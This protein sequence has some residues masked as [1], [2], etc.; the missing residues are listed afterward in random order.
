MQLVTETNTEKQKILLVDK[1][2]SRLLLLLKNELRK[3][4]N[5]VF[6]SPKILPTLNSFDLCFVLHEPFSSIKK[7][8]EQSVNTKLIFIFINRK[9]TAVEVEQYIK[10]Y[11]PS[12]DTYFKC[13]DIETSMHPNDEVLEKILWFTFSESSDTLL[14]IHPKKVEKDSKDLPRAPNR[15]SPIKYAK[16]ERSF[17]RVLF[18]IFIVA[19]LLHFSF[20]PPLILTN[21]L[22]YKTVQSVKEDFSTSIIAYKQAQFFYNITKNLYNLARPT[23]QLISLAYYTDNPV[24]IDDTV[25]LTFDKAISVHDS[26]NAF[27]KLL[28]K[29]EKTQ[30]D[31]DAI[32]TY[33]KKL[34]N[35][36]DSFDQY[37]SILSQ[38]IP[39]WTQFTNAKVTL[40]EVVNNTKTV[41]KLLP[42]FD[43][44]F[45]KDNNKKYLILFANNMELRPGGG[46]IGSFGIL[47]VHN[48]TVEP[49]KIYDVYDADGQLK[50]H[51]DPP[52]PIREYLQQPHWFL[53]DSAFS[54]DFQTNYAEAKLFL[55]EE[56]K[57][58]N[59]D[60]GIL[61]TTS[62]IQN[63]LEGMGDLY[64]PDFKESVNKN[65]FYIKAQLYS[66]KNFFPGSTQKKRFL[67]SVANQMIANLEHTSQL[68]LLQMVK[69]SLEEKQL[70]L[71]FE[72]S[73]L[74]DSIDS[75]YWS[76]KTLIPKC[77]PNFPT[78]INNYLYPFEANLGVNKANFFIKKL[79]SMKTVIN[80]EGVAE[81]KLFFKF[82]NE[83]LT[84]VFPGGTYKN[85][86]Q[87]MIP[88]AAQVEHL[89][90]NDTLIEKY[91]VTDGDSK[92]LGFFIEI[93][94]QSTS[95]IEIDYSLDTELSQGKGAYQLI[96]QKQVGSP[97]S[98]FKFDLSYPKT[99]HA[100][101][102]NFSPLVK[103]NEILY[104]T[105]LTADKIFFI[106]LFKD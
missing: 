102:Q 105:T 22:F 86:F 95:K 20:I 9:K 31:M 97:N 2:S 53:R 11:Y 7:I 77:P 37:L 103:H 18:Y 23:F 42:Q 39:N 98:Q 85:Y 94:P 33:K 48:Y 70:V 99:I 58:D 79:V 64:I 4:D 104:N 72:D 36:L 51:I 15:N 14:F 80:S 100:V 71:Y 93:P 90:K 87:V 60:G 35:D 25:S 27:T 21:L 54:P 49:V 44:I 67:G 17:K 41:Q 76:G 68:K 50:T 66:E 84:D 26:A 57:F 81:N 62:T 1:Y 6:V 69:K 3:Y 55:K 38:K 75:L 10:R 16:K 82:T 59:F 43:T 30:S 24:Q 12:K 73:K 56:M 101:S 45:A 13:I 34:T 91:D 89:T 65:N 92:T 5:E 63:I 96:V 19:A 32:Q 83:S 88:V 29:K 61:L 74:Q 46:F 8:L 40:K 106:E 47:N 78:C 52:A 28:L